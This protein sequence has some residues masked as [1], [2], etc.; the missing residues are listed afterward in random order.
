M[1]SSKNKRDNTIA[2]EPSNMIRDLILPE[3]EEL[4]EAI[5]LI[6]TDPPTHEVEYNRQVIHKLLWKMKTTIRLHEVGGQC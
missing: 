6:P 4:K 1:S 5:Q 2:S 3:L